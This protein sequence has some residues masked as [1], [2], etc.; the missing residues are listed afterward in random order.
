MVL[1]VKKT[2]RVCLVHIW[3]DYAAGLSLFQNQVAL[4]NCLTAFLGD[5]LGFIQIHFF[6]LGIIR[7]FFHLL[8]GFFFVFFV[9]NS[10]VGLVARGGNKF[11]IRR[12][13]FFLGALGFALGGRCLSA[14]V[15]VITNSSYMKRILGVNFLGA[16]DTP[17]PAGG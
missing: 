11:L 10:V 9:I 6:E 13:V 4:L 16:R 2:T 3:H 15:G 5:G 7:C 8:F 14:V 17:R 12:G 1:G